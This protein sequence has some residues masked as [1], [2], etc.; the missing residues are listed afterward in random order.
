MKK[1]DVKNIFQN[2]NKV[3]LFILFS[4][5]LIWFI[6]KLSKTYTD[7][8]DFNYELTNL[9]KDLVIKK[10]DGNQIKVQLEAT[11]I[12][13]IGYH[14]FTTTIDINFDELEGEKNEYHLTNDQIKSVVQQ[15]IEIPN[16]T[17]AVKTKTLNFSSY[18]LYAKKVGVHSR[19]DVKFAPGYDSIA[20][21]QFFPDS[22][23]LYGN[24]K[25]LDTL[26]G[27]YTEKKT[28]SNVKESLED[29]IAIEM[30]DLDIKDISQEEVA[31]Q[32]EVAKYTEK[33]LQLPIEVINVP[34][35]IEVSIF[36]KEIQINFE[37]ELQ[38]YDAITKKD[39]HLLCDFR[40]RDKDDNVLVP[41][42][43]GKPAHI[44]KIRF[45]TTHVNYLIRE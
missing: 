12:K 13:L 27:V 8:I 1:I 24:Q 42:L 14:L 41:Y 31:Y 22:I 10:S 39:F 34:N 20:K 29:H 4:T 26:K 15:N 37:V 30:K 2:S 38:N 19:L 11:G 32:L 16:E 40:K 36:P 3:F 9:P 7:V 6:L 18:Q 21:F 5:S 35:D 17:F 23:T 33:T 44:K 25:I 45:N 28:I 43:K